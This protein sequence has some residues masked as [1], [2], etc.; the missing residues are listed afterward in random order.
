MRSGRTFQLV[1]VGDGPM[2]AEVEAAIR[3]RGL[4]ERVH[5]TGWATGAQVR[6]HLEEARA[7][8]LPSFAEGLPVVLMEALALGR[9]VLTTYI[10]GIPE[11]ISNGQQ[12][13]LFPAGDPSAAA[14]AMIACLD[15]PVDTL[16]AMGESGRS[17]VAQMHDA[18]SN[19]AS[20]KAHI[21][22]VS[23]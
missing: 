19:A 16:R 21:E 22:A 6:A 3:S 1:L 15:A 10:A 23:A 5:I 11:L 9:P 17:R 18:H 4:T 7:L 13:W 8:V 20:L 14:D 2:R 12:G